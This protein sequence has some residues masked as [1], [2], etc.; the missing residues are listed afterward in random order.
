MQGQRVTLQLR[1]S[2]GKELPKADLLSDIDPFIRI[3]LPPSKA[4]AD[5]RSAYDAGISSGAELLRMQT[6][7]TRHFVDEPNAQWCDR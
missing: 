2:R 1:I 3:L 5:L 6:L 4:D 7:Q